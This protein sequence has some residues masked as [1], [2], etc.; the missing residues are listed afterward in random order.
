M[1]HRESARR[2]ERERESSRNRHGS[3]SF[4]GPPFGFS[5]P[6]MS[7]PC[8]RVWAPLCKGAIQFKQFVPSEYDTFPL[9]WTWSSQEL[10]M[11][12]GLS[13]GTVFARG[14][15]APGSMAGRRPGGPSASHGSGAAVARLRAG[16]AAVRDRLGSSVEADGARRRGTNTPSRAPC[17]VGPARC[18]ASALWGD[19]ASRRRGAEGGAGTAPPAA[20]TQLPSACE[21]ERAG[22]PRP[23]TQHDTADALSDGRSETRTRERA[24]G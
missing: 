15:S 9:A 18:W 4:S 16:P 3:L 24:L 21:T 13:C 5:V 17:G 12:G 14:R 11:K 1:R 22:P 20:R 19:V 7:V 8:A 23:R 2:D 6:P 10:V